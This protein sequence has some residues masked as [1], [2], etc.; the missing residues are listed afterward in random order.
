MLAL[1]QRVET[2]RTI[3]LRARSSRRHEFLGHSSVDQKEL[4]KKMPG[5][6]S[7]SKLEQARRLLAGGTIAREDSD[8]ELGY[9]DLPWEWIYAAPSNATIPQSKKRKRENGEHE[10]EIVGA[11]MGSF[12]C[13]VGDIVFLKSADNQA[14]VGLIG[15][16]QEDE[17]GDKLANFMW[18]SSP[19]EIRNKAKKR[20]DF[21][22]VR[23][24]YRAHVSS[25]HLIDHRMSFTSRHPG[26]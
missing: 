4:G 19:A 20:A 24:R 25:Q 3:K 5:R 22:K 16:F 14:W 10:L 7:R 13:R 12:E 21:F 15:E 2:R 26:T 8:D 6:K 9:E 17:D 1:V 18:F 11:R 23:G